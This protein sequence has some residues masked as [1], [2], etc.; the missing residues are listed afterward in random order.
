M[1]KGLAIYQLALGTAVS[2]HMFRSDVE[3]HIVV[4]LL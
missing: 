4:N 1:G 3:T 2:Q